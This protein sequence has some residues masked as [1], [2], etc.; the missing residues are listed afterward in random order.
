MNKIIK[1]IVNIIL[2]ILIVL[3]SIFAVLK[4]ANKVE[5]YKVQTGSMEDNIHTGD[6]ILLLKKSDYNVGD[7]VTF[8][9]KDY[10]VTHRIIKENGDKIITKG[11]ANN[12]EDEEISKK[13]IIGKVVFSGGLLNFIIEIPIL[14]C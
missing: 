1:K 2:I 6:Y 5:I 13:D 10:H 3:I 7:I 11:D 8:K 9:V 14:Q 4:I 12:K